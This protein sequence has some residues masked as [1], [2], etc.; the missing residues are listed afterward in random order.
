[1]SLAINDQELRAQTPKCVAALATAA[2]LLPE[3]GSKVA[4]VVAVDDVEG[5][6]PVACN[7]GFVARR[8]R[9]LRWGW[10]TPKPECWPSDLRCATETAT[11]KCAAQV[12]VPT[13]GQAAAITIG[14][15]A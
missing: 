10:Q 8:D 1:M 13:I 2:T 9:L 7:P 6:T 4:G 12:T 5:A 14:A 3:K 15:R 11:T